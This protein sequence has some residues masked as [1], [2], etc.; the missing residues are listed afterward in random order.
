MSTKQADEGFAATYETSWGEG[1]VYVRGGELVGVDLP[2]EAGGPC[3]VSG[4]CPDATPEGADAEA[5]S[6]WVGEL[7]AY[8]RG[9]RTTWTP[10]EVPLGHLGVGPFE[11]AV[12]EALLSV[13]PG[14]TGTYGELAELAG[15]PRAGR[16]VGNAM[17]TNPLPVVVPC[18]RVIRANG[19]LGNYGKDPRWKER[20]LLH[21]GWVRVRPSGE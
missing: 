1:W 8:F 10:G 19:T 20:L 14:E 6:F 2:G 12:Y 21:E 18:H 16:A 7:E 15:Y 17:A 5:V 11:R 4:E 13:P 9:E 3:T